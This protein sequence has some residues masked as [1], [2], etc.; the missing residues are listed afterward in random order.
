MTETLA[1]IEIPSDWAADLAALVAYVREVERQGGD[2]RDL[3]AEERSIRA[4]LDGIGRMA[5]ARLMKCADTTAS[6]VECDGVVWGNRRVT[7]ADSFTTFGPVTVP[8]S[9]YQRGGRGRVLV[10]M[11]AR[12]GLF[13]GRYTPALARA[14]SM[15]VAMAPAEEATTLFAELGV[16]G[17]SVST[18]HRVPQAIAARYECRKPDVD[19]QIRERSPIPHDAVAVQVALDGVM[20]PQDGQ[21]AKA[22]GRAPKDGEPDPPRHEL[23][24]TLPERPIPAANDGESGRAWHEA[25]VG[26]LH[27]VDELGKPRGT[28]YLG[29]MPEPKKATLIDDLFAELSSVIAERPDVDIVFASDGAP[30]HWRALEKFAEAIAPKHEGRRF[31]VL[32][33]FHAA[34]Y[35]TTAANVIWGDKPEAH[36]Q[37]AKWREILRRVDG[38]HDKVLDSLRYFRDQLASRSRR[39]KL[40]DVIAYLADHANAGRMEYAKLD[41]MFLPIG[42]GVVE[43]AA[44]TLVSVRMKRAGARYTQHGGQTILTFRAAL[45]SDRFDDLMA[46]LHA[47]YVHEVR[48]V[49][50]LCAA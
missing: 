47:T 4:R 2:D 7:S 42:S 40:E 34:E 33:F 15:A 21:Q 25:S 13:E 23:G 31:F 11:E 39:E 44:K 18:L 41:G 38:G 6:E 24:Y 14:M 9:T 5:M 28:T 1:S 22:R 30:L 16:A 29:R 3:R 17:V 46:I 32:D 8:R 43:A 37:A 45:A 27:F 20:V 10:P 50:P 19:A 35:L 49:R 36:A 48:E 12:L 26:T